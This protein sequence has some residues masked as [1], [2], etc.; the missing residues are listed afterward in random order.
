MIKLAPN[1]SSTQKEPRR[2]W[3]NT[4]WSVYAEEEEEDH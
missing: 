4:P 3:G 2:S 1:R